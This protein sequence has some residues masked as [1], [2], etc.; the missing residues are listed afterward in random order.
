MIL[1]LA[2][3]TH[4]AFSTT[5]TDTFVQL[6][7]A[8]P[9]MVIATTFCED[10]TAALWTDPTA[11]TFVGLWSTDPSLT[12][13]W[14]TPAF[15]Y[16]I[17][18]LSVVNESARSILP[19]VEAASLQNV[20]VSTSDSSM[21]ACAIDAQFTSLGLLR[22]LN[23]FKL[24]S[25]N[26]LYELY[27]TA[28]G[29]AVNP[30]QVVVAALNDFCSSWATAN[31]GALT[32]GAT[33]GTVVN[34]YYTQDPFVSSC[35]FALQL[36]DGST[37]FAASFFELNDQPCSSW[38]N[39]YTC[40]LSSCSSCTSCYGLDNDLHCSSWCN[41]WTCGLTHCAGCDSC[42][43]LEAGEHCSPWCNSFTCSFQHCLGCAV[44]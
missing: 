17:E 5:T 15:P 33:G 23:R 9:A 42:A 38:C 12:L 27:V 28:L 43:V 20:S 22:I 2:A 31:A 10:Y 26:K 4:A 3:G 21:V 24:D 7:A 25:S 6:D 14:T 29:F 37:R 13:T 41:V 8:N 16:I 36:P 32:P 34:A 19:L 39:V 18:G 44:C 11:E 30:T 40:G 35:S 1:T